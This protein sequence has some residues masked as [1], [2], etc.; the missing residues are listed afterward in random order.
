MPALTPSNPSE[1]M[2]IRKINPFITTLSVP[3][4]RFGRLR[5]GGRGTLVKLQSG[6]IAVFSPPALTPEVKKTVEELGELK[7]IAAPDLEHHIFLGPWHEA[8]PNAKVIGPEGLP[9]KREKA[10]NE[11]VPFAAIFTKA[12]RETM[13]IDPE[14]DAEFEYEYMAAHTNKEIAFFH[15]PT[16]TLIEADVL[17]NLPGHE[18]FSKTGSPADEGYLTKLWIRITNTQGAAMGQRR[19]QWYGLSA[20]DREGFAKS[21]QKINAWD[22]DRIIP[23]HGEVI[24]TGGKSIF[25]KVFEWHL[26]S[27]KSDPKKTV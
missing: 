5:V 26:T 9:E 23:C 25:Q 19:L 20:G 10:K 6:G 18:Q 4:Y 24:E 7:Y 13:V 11:A 27:L 3:F 1:V 8:Y 17:F 22:F 14:F 21:V 16:K 2:V 12:N 15:K